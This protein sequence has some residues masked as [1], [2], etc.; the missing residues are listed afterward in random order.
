M[1]YFGQPLQEA[2]AH[3]RSKRWFINPNAGFKRQ[4]GNYDKFL[5]KDRPS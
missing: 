5:A 4:L 2:M 3:V 1:K